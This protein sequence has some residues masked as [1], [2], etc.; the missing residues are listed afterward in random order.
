[1]GRSQLALMPDDIMAQMGRK[2]F[3]S[4]LQQEERVAGAVDARVQCIAGHIT[5]A[6]ERLYPQFMPPGT[7]EVAVFANAMPN[8]FAM[9]GLRIG[10]FEGMLALAENDA[11]LAAVIGHEVGHVLASHSNERVTQEFGIN[12]I[13]LL[14]GL[15]SELDSILVYQALGL[16]AQYGVILP[17]S[18]AHESEADLIGLRLM[19][20]AG[21]APEESNRLNSCLHT[22]ATIRELQTSP[23]PRQVSQKCTRYQCPL[24]VADVRLRHSCW[25][26]VVRASAGYLLSVIFGPLFHPACAPV[27]HHCVN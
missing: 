18:R 8:A 10:V 13:L 16:G 27:H 1:M 3:A 20:A 12:L 2:A 25:Q 4:M 14:I 11:Q 23:R 7:W 19:A 17:F 15:F 22:R 6:A 9:P 26:Y 5:A 21:Y 24:A